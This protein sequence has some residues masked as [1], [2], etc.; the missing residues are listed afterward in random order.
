MRQQ[1]PVILGVVPGVGNI[2]TGEGFDGR[3]ILPPT[4]RDNLGP[5]RIEIARRN[6]STKVSLSAPVSGDSSRRHVVDILLFQSAAYFSAPLSQN[7]HAH[8]LTKCH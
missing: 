7:S 8:S 5:L 1:V 4:E 3:L 6:H 2:V